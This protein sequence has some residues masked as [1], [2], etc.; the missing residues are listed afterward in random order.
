MKGADATVEEL[1][2]IA[3]VYANGEDIPNSGGVTDLGKLHETLQ[4][5]CA[6]SYFITILTHLVYIDSPIRV[7]LIVDHF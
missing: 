1:Y 6:C 2:V 3:G 7:V 4:N 5:A